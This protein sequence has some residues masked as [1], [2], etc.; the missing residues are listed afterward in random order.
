MKRETTAVIVA[1]ALAACAGAQAA[2]QAGARPSDCPLEFLY[3]APSQP[4]DTLG[5]L[6]IQTTVPVHGSAVEV[7]RPAGCK[8]GADAI[9]VTRNQV[10]DLFD[11]AMVEGTAIRFRP[12]APPP[13]AEASPSEPKPDETPKP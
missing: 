3:K 5:E 9:I 6:Q 8:L 11:H 4:Y 12:A 10:L 13:Q 7:M 2:S 1:F